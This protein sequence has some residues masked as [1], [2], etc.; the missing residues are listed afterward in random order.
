MQSMISSLIKSPIFA[1]M[2]EPEIESCLTCS[3]SFTVSYKKDDYIFRQFDKPNRL[4]LLLSGTVIIGRNSYDGKR[5]IMTTYHH[6]GDMFGD[7]FL[8]LQKQNYEY[9]AQALTDASV[10]QIPKEFMYHTCGNGCVCHSQMISNMLAILSQKAFYL[11]QRLQIVSS[12]SLRQKI[13]KTLLWHHENTGGS[14]FSLSR[15]DLADFLNAAR[16]SVSRELMKMQ[17]DGL[18]HTDKRR[19]FIDDMERLQELCD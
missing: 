4:L 9:Y 6:P 16:P 10:L 11:T 7:V 13:A 19:I 5:H 3:R 12:S 1:N 8:F 17:Q 15:E 14:S 2:S 18:I